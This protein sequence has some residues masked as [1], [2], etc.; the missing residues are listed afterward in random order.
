MKE[1]ISLLPFQSQLRIAKML[2]RE[3]LVRQ[4]TENWS[5]LLNEYRTRLIAD[6]VTGKLDVREATAKLPDEAE[7]SGGGT[8]MPVPDRADSAMKSKPYEQHSE[9]QS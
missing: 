2:R 8:T 7:G 9:I 1:K 6:V 3:S 5:K 4:E